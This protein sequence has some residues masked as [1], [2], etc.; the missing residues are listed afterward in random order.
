MVPP[1]WLDAGTMRRAKV[2]RK[3]QDCRIDVGELGS[4]RP[5]RPGIGAWSGGIHDQLATASQ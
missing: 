4:G 5:G 3:V 1:A 2:Q